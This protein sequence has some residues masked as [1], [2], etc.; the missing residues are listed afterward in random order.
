MATL[1]LKPQG[2]C[3]RVFSFPSLELRCV[4][5]IDVLILFKQLKLAK[6]RF[7][8]KTASSCQATGVVTVI[9]WS[10]DRKQLEEWLASKGK[11]Y[12]RPPMTLLQ[13][14][15]VKPSWSKVKA[16]EEQENPGQ[17]CQAKINNILTECL[18]LVEEVGM[19]KELLE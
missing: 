15:A 5:E 19:G 13:K 17:H 12:K 16:K 7:Q 2:L 6:G 8:G 3:L 1:P 14:Q 11:K 10:L 18:K 4:S 9:S